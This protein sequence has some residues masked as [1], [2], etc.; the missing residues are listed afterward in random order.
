MYGG[1]LGRGK[2]GNVQLFYFGGFGF[3]LFVGDFKFGGLLNGGFGR[4]RLQGKLRDV[5]T[6]FTHGC[7]VLSLSGCSLAAGCDGPFGLLANVEIFLVAQTFAVE[8]GIHHGNVGF[9]VQCLVGEQR[10]QL[11][12][13]GN[14]G[15]V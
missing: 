1:L 12:L 14:D 13:I 15:G 7:F 4:I 8:H 10:I 3:H 11:F 2:R 9:N 5:G 6:V